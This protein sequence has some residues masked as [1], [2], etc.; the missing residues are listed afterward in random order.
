MQA[1]QF[2]TTRSII[3]EAGAISRLGE[4]CAQQG[5]KKPLIVTDKGIVE[6]GLLARLTDSLDA[7]DIEYGCFADVVADPP[8]S[9][10][11]AALVQAKQ[12]GIDG[13]IGFGGGSSMDTAKVVAPLACSTP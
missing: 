7:A 3:S 2:N 12:E 4:I 13:V 9:V 5:I 8:E 1:F 11:L 10:V 6:L